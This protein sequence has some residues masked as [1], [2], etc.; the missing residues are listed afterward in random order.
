MIGGIPKN[1]ESLKA[2]IDGIVDS[3]ATPMINAGSTR[4]GG[5]QPAQGGATDIV[6]DDKGVGH[7]YKGSGARNDP[8]SY[9][10]VK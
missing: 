4:H 6:Y 3:A 2:A 10:Q 1:P 5:N 8:N 9:E 7:R